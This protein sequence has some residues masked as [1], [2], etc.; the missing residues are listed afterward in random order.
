MAGHGRVHHIGAIPVGVHDVGP[1]T[2][3][4]VFQRGALSLVRAAGE[5]N[6]MRLDCLRKSRKQWMILTAA[7]QHCRDMDVAQGARLASR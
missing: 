5:D 1:K 3:A 7:V 4:Q 6:G 2:P